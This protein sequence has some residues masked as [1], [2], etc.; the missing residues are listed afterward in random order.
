MRFI[1]VSDLHLGKRVHEFSMVDDQQVMLDSI[2]ELCRL[3]KPNAIVIAGDIYDK[4]IPSVEAIDLFENFLIQLSNLS[5][6]ILIVAGNHDSGERLSFGRSFLEKHNIH[7]AGVFDGS[8]PCVEVV[9]D[10]DGYKT[11]FHLMPFIRAGMVRRFFP[12]RE[13]KTVEEA[14]EAALSTVIRKEGMNVIIAHQFVIAKGSNLLRSDSEMLQVGTADEINV[15]VFSG[16]DYVALGHLH[17]RQQVGTDHVYYSGSPLPYSFSEANHVKG[18]LVVDLSPDKI[19]TIRQKPLARL[20]DM[21]RIRGTLSELLE[22]GEVMKRDEDKSRLDYLE[23]TLT[24]QGPVT[25]P[26]NRLREYYP[27][28][29]RLLFDRERSEEMAKGVLLSKADL[30]KKSAVDLFTDFFERQLGRKMSDEQLS[31]VRIVAQR[32]E[33]EAAGG[34]S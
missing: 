7:I 21:R 29:M 8:V 11:N 27:Y 17:G 4:A 18:A 1:H 14:V 12:D 6:P 9:C 20:R 5:I 25:D 23:V 22:Q 32:A 28:I 33:E 13:I 19:V 30:T 16:F 10:E 15:D 26:M 24:D 34:I 3:E 2:V 31:V